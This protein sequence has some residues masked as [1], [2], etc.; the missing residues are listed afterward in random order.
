MGLASPPIYFPSLI[1][2]PIARK[3]AEF[4]V[5]SDGRKMPKRFSALSRYPT[6]T[7]NER[8]H[9][10]DRDPQTGLGI[11]PEHA[12]N[13]VDAVYR[14][15]SRHVLATLIRLLGDFDVAEEALHDAFRAA[16]EQWPRDG[17]PANPR[18]WLVS[19]GRFKAIDA[20]RRRSPIHAV[21]GRYR[22]ATRGGH[23]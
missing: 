14:S 22:Q 21:A 12:R 4:R 8:Q 23:R 11:A 20:I 3:L 16:L 7:L 15:D 5:R 18:A 6:L 2:A 19:T 13:T 1:L 17:V 9:V 10:M